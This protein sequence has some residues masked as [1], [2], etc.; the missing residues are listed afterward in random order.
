[1]KLQPLTIIY[2]ESFIASEQEF[3]V[4]IQVSEPEMRIYGDM[5]LWIKCQNIDDEVF[6][7]L[8]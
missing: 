8:V 5:V 1:M 4:Q 6:K 2:E 7:L 3:T